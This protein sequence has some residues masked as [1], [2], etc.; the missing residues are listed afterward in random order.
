MIENIKKNLFKIQDFKTLL[1][2][3]SSPFKQCSSDGYTTDYKHHETLCI[4]EMLLYKIYG[5]L[6][7]K[8]QAEEFLHV[9]ALE[10]VQKAKNQKWTLDTMRRADGVVVMMS[11][12][13]HD[14]ETNIEDSIVH[15]KEIKK[16][17]KK[18]EKTLESFANLKQKYNGCIDFKCLTGK[19][20]NIM[21]YFVFPK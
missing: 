19:E 9:K 12:Q 21:I 7:Q 15:M 3:V 17:V 13:H 14:K 1:K 5:F 2:Q 20:L 4:N 18:L 10:K 16:I 11:L 6:R 8:R